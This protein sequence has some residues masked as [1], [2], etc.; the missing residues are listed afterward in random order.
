MGGH[1]QL[2]VPVGESSRGKTR[3]C[4]EAVRTLP[5]DWRI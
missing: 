5:P 2:V 4:W 3:A 1:S